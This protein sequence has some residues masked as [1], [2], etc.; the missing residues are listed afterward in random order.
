[1]TEHHDVIFDEPFPHGLPGSL[2]SLLASD[3]SSDGSPHVS[4]D[5]VSYPLVGSLV[6]GSQLVVVDLSSSPFDVGPPICIPL[7]TSSTVAGQSA[8]TPFFLWSLLSP[9]CIFQSSIFRLG[10]KTLVKL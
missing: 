5:H 9:R 6:D 1:M 3:D 7:S 4:M 8:G 10:L 2:P